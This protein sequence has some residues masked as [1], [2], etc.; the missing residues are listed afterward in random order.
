MNA[1][2]TL[3][4]RP[5][6]HRGLVG[7][8]ILLGLGL[9]F[10]ANNMG[11]LGWE[12]W[13]T[14]L[15]LW[16]LLLIAIGLDL[17]IGRRSALGSALVL[18]VL[19]GALGVAVWWSGSWGQ[20]GIPVAGETVTQ[21]LDGATRADVAIGMGVGT[22]RV[23]GLD[24]SNTLINATVQRVPGAQLFRNFTVNGDTAVFQLRSQN[25]WFWMFPSTTQRSDQITWDLQLN[26]TVPMHLTV[27][28]GA[29]T[30]RLDLTQL[31]ITDLD[32]NI[33]V[34]MTTLTMP[35]QGRVQAQVH[36]GVG[37]TTIIIPAGVAARISATAG[38]GSVQVPSSYQRQD[39]VYLSPGYDSA[40]D[41]MDLQ[42]HGGVGSITILQSGR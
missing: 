34:G 21:T 12:V 9:I 23:R 37:E 4:E 38:L 24:D 42:V 18:V 11:W 32:V 40:A 20:G 1:V 39:K 26:Q 6:R 16:P 22:L 5:M 10:L 33:G 29:G 8:A 3:P 41:R 2:Q 31:H 7:P 27:D 17:L 36:G 30:A 28:T 19:L 35:A 14:L 15:R 13:E 25:S